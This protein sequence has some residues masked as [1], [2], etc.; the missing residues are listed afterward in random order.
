MCENKK[1]FGG[2]DEAERGCG[3]LLGA[4][5][6]FL[7]VHVRNQYQHA[8]QQGGCEGCGKGHRFEQ[9]GRRVEQRDGCRIG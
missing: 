3:F 9:V 8:E 2:R 5:C 7:R 4:G 6:G 1:G